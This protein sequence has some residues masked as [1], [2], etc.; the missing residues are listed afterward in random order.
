MKT[1]IPT[2]WLVLLATAGTLG[3]PFCIRDTALVKDT[4]TDVASTGACN[5]FKRNDSVRNVEVVSGDLPARS[6]DVADDNTLDARGPC[7]G[8]VSD[9]A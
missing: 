4:D 1:P 7:W 5:P 8:V 9:G 6:A 3:A 2:L